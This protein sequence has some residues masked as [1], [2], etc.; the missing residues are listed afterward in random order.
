VGH[1][2]EPAATAYPRDAAIAE[3]RAFLADRPYVRRDEIRTLA[4]HR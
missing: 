2:A 1:T 3:A 4:V